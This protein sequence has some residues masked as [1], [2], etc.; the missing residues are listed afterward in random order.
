MTAQTLLVLTSDSGCT[1]AIEADADGSIVLRNVGEDSRLGYV[2]ADATINSLTI[3]G[4]EHVVLA[5]P[6]ERAEHQ[7]TVVLT[8]FDEHTLPVKNGFW[9]SWPLTYVQDMTVTVIW[10]DSA[11]RELFRLTSPPLKTLPHTMFGPGWTTYG[12]P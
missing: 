7:Q 11:S 4:N 12:P 5:G 6:V 9:M 2:H 10:Q 3:S 8:E 1:T